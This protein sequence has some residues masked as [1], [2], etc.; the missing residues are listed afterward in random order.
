VYVEVD[1][2]RQDP[3][4]HPQI[5][6]DSNGHP[7]TKKK[8]YFKYLRK[9]VEND[10]VWIDTATGI[11]ATMNRS[12]LLTLPPKTSML[13][14][15]T[16]SPFR[17]VGRNHTEN[18]S[19]EEVSSMTKLQPAHL[20]KEA[21]IENGT[22]L[23]NA[24]DLQ[25][26]TQVGDV[27][28]WRAAADSKPYEALDSLSLPRTILGQDRDD[29]PFHLPVCFEI[30]YQATQAASRGN[31]FALSARWIITGATGNHSGI[32]G[33]YRVVPN[34][35]VN[36]RPVYEKYPTGS[37][38]SA[39][40]FAETMIWMS[41]TPKSKW[42]IGFRRD[43][44]LD[45]G[46]A[47]KDGT[48]LQRRSLWYTSR[49]SCRSNGGLGA[50]GHGFQKYN[51]PREND[52]LDSDTWQGD[53]NIGIFL[54]LFSLF[55]NST[56]QAFKD[57]LSDEPSDSDGNMNGA[58]EFVKDQTVLLFLLDGDWVPCLVTSVNEVL[59]LSAIGHRPHH[60]VGNNPFNIEEEIEALTRPEILYDLE[61]LDTRKTRRK[62]LSGMKLHN[63][64]SWMIA[65]TKRKGNRLC[66]TE[67]GWKHPISAPILDS[68][69]DKGLRKVSSRLRP[70]STSREGDTTDVDVLFSPSLSLTHGRDLPRIGFR[71]KGA[72]RPFLHINGIYVRVEG[73]TVNGCSY[74][75]KLP[76]SSRMR[77][78]ACKSTKG[79]YDGRRK[80]E[81]WWIGDSKNTG[82]PSGDVYL[83]G[84]PGVED[85]WFSNHPESSGDPLVKVSATEILLTDKFLRESSK[86]K[87]RYDIDAERPSDGESTS[88]VKVH[89]EIH[90]APKNPFG[91]GAGRQM[92]VFEMNGIALNLPSEKLSLYS[93]ARGLFN[94]TWDVVIADTAKNRRLKVVGRS[95]NSVPGKWISRSNTSSTNMIDVGD[96]AQIENISQKS[97]VHLN[98]LFARVLDVDASH[99][100][101]VVNVAVPVSKRRD[102]R[103]TQK[104]NLRISNLRPLNTAL[105]ASNSTSSQSEERLTNLLL[106]PEANF[107]T[108]VAKGNVVFTFPRLESPHRID[109]ISDYGMPKSYPL[110]SGRDS[111]TT[112]QIL[113]SIIAYSGCDLSNWQDSTVKTWTDLHSLTRK[114]DG[115]Y[116]CVL[117]DS[118]MAE[119]KEKQCW[120]GI[121]SGDG[122]IV[123]N[124]V[125][126]KH[127][128]VKPE[129]N[130][131]RFAWYP[132]PPVTRQTSEHLDF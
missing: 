58:G 31:I 33:A 108:I 95:L 74:F 61:V 90:G 79:K 110:E 64:P 16:A 59:P 23:R 12:L 45:H 27:L 109:P 15:I 97:H 94:D 91:P 5:R 100:R 1:G 4:D 128:R 71:V 41:H 86:K 7:I 39:S 104:K 53:H 123:I 99:Q 44:G 60:E 113:S 102:K 106:N 54:N 34:V 2:P 35:L 129:R 103:K 14:L 131:L 122:K 111:N 40:N 63:V 18:K 47:W 115:T 11:S 89:N 118:S 8:K 76:V 105:N 119:S 25:K 82:L 69:Q 120:G 96:L 126:G 73:R 92:P 43:L 48:D 78:W 3:G 13:Q 21:L 51:R 124:N 37:N 62:K 130:A 49:E 36:G 9:H 88:T 56:R 80:V 32:N 17:R 55:P 87:A 57:L 84:T 98:G 117:S 30:Q 24:P 72:E 132:A 67:R 107:H 75:T 83:H 127:I 77:L 26:A 68:Y 65:E 42:V 101:A 6:Q 66:E 46:I 50:R 116:D 19:S 28:S 29:Y 22:L 93:V 38:T 81:T 114:A 10:L 85:Y 70:D 112:Y 121:S 20:W 125:R 52:L